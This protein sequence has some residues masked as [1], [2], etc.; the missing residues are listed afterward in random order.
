MIAPITRAPLS[1]EEARDLTARIN[2]TAGDLCL[3]LLEAHEREAWRALGYDSW[4][5]YATAELAISQSKAYRVLD[6]GRVTAALLA[7]VADESDADFSQ[8]REKSP[9]NETAARE[10]LPV[11][12]AVVAN[13][14]ERVAAGTPPKEAVAAAVAAHRPPRS[15]SP[16]EP[17]AADAQSESD[18]GD[19]APDVLAEWE[20]AEKEVERLTALVESLTK[21]DTAR[22]LRAIS[23]RYAQLDARHRQE[24]TTA[25]EAVKQAKY[26]TGVLDKVRAELHVQKYSEIVPAIQALRS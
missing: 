19:H 21:D 13:V 3:L 25:N 6:V 18:P 16:P 24:I 5:A 17:A 26:L 23:A 4:R 8:I 9:I 20:R 22:E 11:L 10:I 12:P 14:K 7:A 2:S 15:A 1:A